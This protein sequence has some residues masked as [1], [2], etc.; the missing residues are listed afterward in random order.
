MSNILRAR[1]YLVGSPVDHVI[2]RFSIPSNSIQDAEPSHLVDHLIN[3]PHGAKPSS[4]A[5]SYR[6]LDDDPM[7]RLAAAYLIREAKALMLE[8]LAAEGL[9]D[10]ATKLHRAATRMDHAEAVI[11]MTAGGGSESMEEMADDAMDYFMAL[12]SPGESA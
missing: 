2:A 12:P 9:E 3:I 7:R 8:F 6:T 5:A 1:D 4:G 10:R 11:C